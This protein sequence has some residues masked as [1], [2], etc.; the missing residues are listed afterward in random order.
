[1]EYIVGI[2][3]YV[4]SANQEDVVKTF[5]LSTCVG[6]VI[7][8]INKKILAMAHVLLP[9]TIKGNEADAYSSAKYADTAVF[10]VVRD[11][12][13]KYKC[14][15]HDL[16]VSLFGGIDAEIDDYFRVGEKN[17]VII[18][19]ILNKMNIRYDSANTGGRVLRTV[20]AYTG[21]GDIDDKTIPILNRI[22]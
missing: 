14:N 21:T 20:I 5:A 13:I 9:K 18:K 4:I 22:K 1:M 16:K 2:G 17:L 8:D 19:E 3:E 10:N 15:M 6:I 11:M 7:Y 12:K